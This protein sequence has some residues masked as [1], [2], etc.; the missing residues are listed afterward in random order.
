M[1]VITREITLGA[2]DLRSLTWFGDTLVDWAA[3]GAR[4]G[5]DGTYDPPS[6]IFAQNDHAYD[7]AVATSDGATAVI[8]QRGGTK[9]LVIQHGEVIK[10]LKRD[11]YHADAYEYPVCIWTNLEGQ[12]LLAHCPDNYSKIEIDN[13]DS[14]TRLTKTAHE[15]RPADFFHSRLQVNPAG[16]RLLSAGWVWHPWDAVLYFDL[17]LALE[18]PR[19]LDQIEGSTPHSRH[20]G[21]AEESSACW[22]NN[23][24]LLIAGSEEE[25]DPEEANEY[26][27]V[28]RLHPKGIVVYDILQSTCLTSVTLSEPAGTMMPVGPDHV[29]ALFRHPRLISL[30]DGAVVAEWPKIS[31]GNQ[32]SSICWPLKNRVPPI[33]LDPL[34]RRVAIG[35]GDSKIHVLAFE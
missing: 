32:R 7:A 14:G 20:V 1:S 19:H 17:P 33:A 28:V 3:G 13:L 23:D 26:P 25:E 9:A 15:R 29:L 27:D 24:R 6:V 10:E 2:R 30:K 31:S 5:L 16:T 12:T 21:L 34:H 11:C 22:Q 35:Q 18:D 4:Y 8:Y